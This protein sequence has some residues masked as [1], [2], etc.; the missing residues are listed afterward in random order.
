MRQRL[1]LVALLK[2]AKVP[3]IPCPAHISRQA[4]ALPQT[5][6]THQSSRACTTRAIGL[7]KRAPPPPRDAFEGVG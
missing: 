2:L 6:S 7:V 4:E 5:H 3:S 1:G